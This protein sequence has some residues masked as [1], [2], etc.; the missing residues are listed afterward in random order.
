ME[1]LV[2][3]EISAETD[4]VMVVRTVVEVRGTAVTFVAV[5]V[6]VK[7]EIVAVMG[8]GMVRNVAA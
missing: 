3:I 2:T 4:F 8:H 7:L 5:E 1:G 6:R